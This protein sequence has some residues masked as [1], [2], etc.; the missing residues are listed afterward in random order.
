M[1]QITKT[2]EG[3]LSD[4]SLVYLSNFR[5]ADRGMTYPLKPLSKALCSVETKQAFLL[6]RG[7]H[8]ASF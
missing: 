7:T 4:S 5:L 8:L 6:H 3:V 1:S 2:T